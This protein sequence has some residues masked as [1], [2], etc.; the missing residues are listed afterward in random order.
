ME[1]ML[2]RRAES[3]R[4]ARDAEQAAWVLQSKLSHIKE[5]KLRDTG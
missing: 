5:R 1:R 4:D 3:R 2:G